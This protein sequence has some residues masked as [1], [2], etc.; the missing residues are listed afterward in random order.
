MTTYKPNKLGQTDLVFW[1]NTTSTAYVI[2]T[3]ITTVKALLTHKTTWLASWLETI[4][5]AKVNNCIVDGSLR[6]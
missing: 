5:T 1:N 3:I 2:I 6:K 4:L